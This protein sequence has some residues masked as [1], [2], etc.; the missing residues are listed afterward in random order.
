MDGKAVARSIKEKTANKVEE[1]KNKNIDP[2]AAIVRVGDDEASISYERAAIRKLEKTGIEA[3]S[4][5]YPEDITEEAFLDEF[6]KIN[7]NS[8]VHGILLLRPLPAHIDEQKV[9][10]LIHP[11]KDIDGMS[12]I[13]MGKILL[14]ESDGLL[15]C[16]PAAVMEVLNYYD[17]ELRG[18]NITVIGHSSVVGKPLSALLLNANATVT[19]CHTYTKNTMELC[20]QA[21]IVVTATGVIDLVTKDHVKDG[22]IV[23]D[24]GINFTE[25]G[26]MVG[27]VSFDE[28]EKKASYVTPVPGGIGSITT[29]LLGS[30][31]AAAAEKLSN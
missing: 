30:Q 8:N 25:D 14:K 31:L 6:T 17:I 23:I 9:S 26:T 21:D 28:V 5:A 29:T 4:Y 15:P 2:Q 7:E 22:A 19:T 13:N 27:D 20:Q 24:V 11:D 10:Y 3:K 18:K 12:P 1:L 16:T